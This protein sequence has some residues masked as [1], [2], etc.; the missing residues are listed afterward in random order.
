MLWLQPLFDI[1]VF[2][3]IPMLFSLKMGGDDYKYWDICQHINRHTTEIK[4][5][6]VKW[7]DRKQYIIHPNGADK[8]G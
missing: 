8:A 7:N 6:N 3:L 2:F 4:K 1:S 5:Q